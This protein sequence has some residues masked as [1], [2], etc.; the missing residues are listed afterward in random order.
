MADLILSMQELQLLT[1]YCQPCKQLEVLKRRGFH[2]A[3]LGRK[4]QVV[5]ERSHFEAVCRGES[6]GF[7]RDVNLTFMKAR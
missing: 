4:G 2:R 6:A 5:L 1:N 7:H 3:Y